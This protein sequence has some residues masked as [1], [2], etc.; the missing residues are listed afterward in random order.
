VRVLL[1]HNRYRSFGGE[2]RHVDLLEEGLV[3]AGVE[4][5]RFEKASAE[6][7]TTFR[8]RLA[9]GVGMTYR[10]SSARSI[11]RVLAAWRPDIVHVHNVLPLLTPSILREA[12][13]H[14]ASVVL[15]AHNCRLFCPGGMGVRRG[16]IHHDCVQGSSLG[17]G[18]RKARGSCAESVAYGIAI[19]LQRRLRLVERWV[20]AYVTPS[21]FLRQHLVSAGLPA[22]RVRLVRNGVRVSKWRRTTREF[23]LYAGRLVPEKGV[24]T[25]LEAS[26]LA[27]DVPLLIAG[28]GPLVSEVRTAANGTITV[29]GFLPSEALRRLR[30]RAAFA[31]VPSESP[32]VLP[33]AA[34]EAIAEGTPVITTELGGLPEIARDG[35][36]VV[37]PAGDAEALAA[38]MRQLWRRSQTEPNFGRAAWESAGRRFS[39]ARQTKQLVELYGELATNENAVPG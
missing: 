20:D 6:A 11:R 26:K 17:F 5:R 21:V 37:I 29:V 23:A 7:G 13:R 12:K 3:D 38:A 39:L 32:D 4:V 10:P 34:V 18:F 36:G 30:A 33:F 9:V 25:L 1:A 19:E 16:Q 2:E 35:A 15:T 28:D 24:R 27:P 8:K 14:G 31:V 22:E